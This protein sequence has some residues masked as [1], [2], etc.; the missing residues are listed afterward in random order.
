[1]R[2]SRSFALFLLG[3]FVAVVS[4]DAVPPPLNPVPGYP[5]PTGSDFGCTTTFD[6]VDFSQNDYKYYYFLGQYL[7]TTD[8]ITLQ[9]IGPRAIQDY[10]SQVVPPVVAAFSIGPNLKR[11]YIIDSDAATQNLKVFNFDCNT[12]YPRVPVA[13]WST[14]TKFA[15]LPVPLTAAVSLLSP[16][17]IYFLGG[18]T[19][20]L[21]YYVYSQTGDGVFGAPSALSTAPWS[22]AVQAGSLHMYPNSTSASGYF[23]YGG[24]QVGELST[25]MQPVSANYLTKVSDC[26]PTVPPPMSGCCQLPPPAVTYP[27]TAMA[28]PPCG[29][30]YDAIDLVADGKY[31]MFYGQSL[32]TADKI[33]MATT[34][35]VLITSVFG[36]IVPP[37]IAAFTTGPSGGRTYLIDSDPVD[38]VKMY[39]CTAADALPRTAVGGP[40]IFG[41][42]FPDAGAS[43]PKPLV[44]AFAAFTPSRVYFLGGPAG[45]RSVTM[46]LYNTANLNFAYVGNT[47]TLATTGMDFD[48]LTATPIYIPQNGTLMFHL[49]SLNKLATVENS[50]KIITTS[51]NSGCPAWMPYFLNTCCSPPSGSTLATAIPITYPTSAPTMNCLGNPDSIDLAPDNNYYFFIGSYFYT[52]H[53]VTSALAQPKPI[54]T[55]FSGVQY[56]VIAAFTIGP[57]NSR[58]FII[59][60]AATNNVKMYRFDVGTA[61][62]VP[63]KSGNLATFFPAAY[64]IPTPLTSAMAAYIPARVY[65]FGGTAGNRQVAMYSFNTATTTFVALSVTK[66][67]EAIWPTDITAS[68]M[69]YF[70]N[71][72]STTLYT[73]DPTSAMQVNT[74]LAKLNGYA[75]VSSCAKWLPA[76]LSPTCCMSPT[77]LAPAITNAVTTAPAITAAP[78]TGIITIAPVTTAAPTTAAVPTTA[79]IITTAAVITV[80]PTTPAAVTTTDVSTTAGINTATPSTITASNTPTIVITTTGTITTTADTATTTINPSTTADSTTAD[81]PSTTTG[82]STTADS[83]TAD[84]ASTT[85]GASTTADSTTADTASTTTGPSTTADSTTA[86]T[87]ST[88][89]GASTTADSTTADTASTTTGA[90]TT[91]D[92]TTA[93]STTADTASTTTGASTTADSTPATPLRPTPG[94]SHNGRLNHCRHRF[95]HH[96]CEHNARLNHSRLNHRRHRFDHDCCEHDGRLN[97]SRHR[98]DHD[99]REHDGRLNHSLHSLDHDWREPNSRLNHSRHPLDHDWREHNSRL[100]HCRHRLDNDWREHDGRLNHCRHG[101]DYHWCE[102]N[103]RLNHSRHR[104]DNDW[105]EHNGRLN[106]CRHGLDRREHN[107]RLNHSRHRRNHGRFEQFCSPNHDRRDYN[108][109]PNHPPTTVDTA[110]T[111]A[112]ASTSTAPTTVDT[113]ATTTDAITTAAPTTVD[114]A[115]TT[116]GAST[117]TAPTTVDTA[118]TTTDAITTA[119]PTT[120]DTAA[121]TTDVGTTVVTS[122]LDPVTTSLAVTIT[123]AGT[124]PVTTTDAATTTSDISTS[125]ATT[126]PDVTTTAAAATST[127][128]A[129]STA[130]STTTSPTTTNPCTMSMFCGTSPDTTLNA[131]TSINTV[132]TNTF[133]IFK[134]ECVLPVVFTSGSTPV[135]TAGSPLPISAA[136]NFGVVT[137]PTALTNAY[138]DGS[139]KIPRLTDSSNRVFDCTQDPVPVC[140]PSLVSPDAAVSDYS[141][142]YDPGLTTV[143]YASDATGKTLSY[144]EGGAGT[145]P[146]QAVGTSIA[147]GDLASSTQIATIKALQHVN[148]GSDYMVVFGESA[149][150]VPYYGVAVI[151][152]VSNLG[153][154][155]LEWVTGPVPLDNAFGAS[156]PATTPPVDPC[157]QPITPSSPFCTTSP[158]A[159]LGDYIQTRYYLFQGSCALRYEITDTGTNLIMNHNDI[160]QTVPKDIGLFF[161]GSQAISVQGGTVTGA[162]AYIDPATQVI[163][164]DIITSAGAVNCAKPTDA[165]IFQPV[166]DAGSAVVDVPTLTAFADWQNP[167][168]NT[169]CFIVTDKATGGTFQMSNGTVEAPVTSVNL[170]AAGLTTITK[171]TAMQVIYDPDPMVGNAVLQVFGTDGT[172]VAYVAYA[173]LNNLL[174]ACQFNTPPQLTWLGSP[175]TLASTLAGC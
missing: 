28:P 171:I 39:Y 49:A 9:T 45:N 80:T 14:A 173:T 148:D 122:S 88:T 170:T 115:A 2:G 81:T 24:N 25:S 116:A 100:N 1:M 55:A 166:C 132:N 16:S 108:C 124:T 87:A 172:G 119:A 123:A 168:G 93:D 5:P 7:F 147:I 94:A 6:A 31:Y 73:F 12:T 142:W 146:T 158:S 19:P 92:S 70:P 35:P 151:P 68:T 69:F 64:D 18:S 111:T 8:K 128:A 72:G 71:N 61:P 164:Y 118:A 96:W 153:P 117:S 40:N 74:N 106:H 150:N 42:Y 86:D 33:T 51:T 57:L 113:V 36:G 48:I 29:T 159:T 163:R 121:T 114:T 157:A 144:Y 134:G 102:H 17:R 175:V 65:F 66:V 54:T 162:N 52:A 27:P 149:S 139:L 78:T 62:R 169:D 15:T 89:T 30:Q 145:A 138:L 156:C 32:F 77:T 22:L 43:I 63:V 37:V 160:G 83:T 79:G 165:T 126:T 53:K 104:L 26:S 110:A 85:T 59:D 125:A 141:T 56:P 120:V 3:S 129:T 11:T 90:S 13:V 155:A 174:T 46:Y 99:W 38:N 95:D 131:V 50:L 47:K 58:M 161:Y 154:P 103:G 91:A 101:F 97:H 20:Q 34:A 133:N 41:K 67:M 75:T 105:R 23:L 140:S 167:N 137:P 60:S 44:S 130:T 112:G 84:T 152:T 76:I 136:Y 127:P 107:S 98:F 109:S 135:L 21:V 82:A 4:P 143:Y 10:F